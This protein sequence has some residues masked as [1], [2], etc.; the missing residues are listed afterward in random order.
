MRKILGFSIPKDNVRVDLQVMFPGAF[1]I[2]KVHKKIGAYSIEEDSMWVDL[3]ATFPAS[4]VI[5]K[6]RKK[7]ADRRNSVK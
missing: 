3:Q 6:V 4:W 2:P 7:I 5:P 1:V